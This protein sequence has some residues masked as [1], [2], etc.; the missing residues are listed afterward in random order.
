MFKIDRFASR[1][2]QDGK[3]RLGPFMLPLKKPCAAEEQER[4]HAP[5]PPLRIFEP[6]GNDAQ[7]EHVIEHECDESRR[8]D[9]ETA[10]AQIGAPFTDSH[11]PEHKAPGGVVEEFRAGREPTR[12]GEAAH[13][14]R[15]CKAA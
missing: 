13:V 10:K 15:Q 6:S 9:I 7:D 2:R 1:K 8:W 14:A 11:H 3:A 5:W 12:H 4:A